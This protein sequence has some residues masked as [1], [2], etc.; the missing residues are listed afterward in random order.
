[1]QQGRPKST[2]S[3]MADLHWKPGAVFSALIASLV[4]QM[5]RTD[6][7]RW[8]PAVWI[9]A[10]IFAML[11]ILFFLWVARWANRNGHS[12][13]KS[14]VIHLAQGGA[15]LT[16]LLVIF[17]QLAHRSIGLGDA[18][19]VVVLLVVQ[20]ISWYL[21][22]FASVRGFERVSL[23]LC[24]A[25]VF[26]VCCMTNRMDVLVAGSIFAISS[27][28]WLVGLYWSRLESKAID[29]NPKVIAIHASATGI[30]SAAILLCLV[31]ASLVP[32]SRGQFALSGFMPFSGGEEGYQDEF[33]ASGVG[34]G[35]MLAAGNNAT[36]TGA[37]DSNQFIEDNKPS[38]YDVMTDQYEG[39]VFKKQRNRGVA[40][41]VKA[42]HIHDVKQSEQSGKSFRT[43]RNSDRELDVELEDRISTALLQIEGSVP[44]RFAIDCFHHFDGW[45]WSKVDT[46]QE[47]P[48][49][50]A[51]KVRKLTGKPFYVLQRSRQSYFT[52]G[53]THRV[54]VMRLENPNLPS[55]S[56]LKKWHIPRV[57]K[58]NMF[59]WNKSGVIEYD[60]ELIPPQ[61]A[62]DIVG[63][64]PNYHLMRDDAQLAE[65]SL[66]IDTLDESGD[67]TSPFLRLPDTDSKERIGCLAQD[68]TSQAKV[69]WNQ[70]E[71]IVHRFRNE[72]ELKPDWEVSETVDDTVSHF[73][74]QR[75]GPSYMFATSCAMVLRSAGYRTRL[76]SG[77]LIRHEDYDRRSKQSIVTAR[78]FHMW[79]EVCLDGKYWIPL[80][81]TPGYPIPYSTETFWQWAKA[82]FYAYIVAP[83]RSH[84]FTS[85]L[86]TL[87]IA[88]SYVYR[89]ILI[90]NLLLLWWHVVRITWPEGLLATTRQL[91]DV[92]F[93]FAGDARPESKTIQSWYTRV[94]PGLSSGF[95]ELWNI[96]NFCSHPRNFSREDIVS[97][98]QEQISAITLKRIQQLKANQTLPENS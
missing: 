65:N 59:S 39:P 6:Q 58:L 52:Q 5:F 74:D 37:V 22:V 20:T 11:P 23:L 87:A 8:I 15:A 10:V 30:A 61:T 70:V 4:M 85:T 16:A 3:R 31:I 24:G 45:D 84:P 12:N 77:F 9:E 38:M 21:A 80:E 90:T 32:I 46:T 89:A 83:I 71:E 94:E 53:R 88:L 51:I 43:M 79:P 27:L 54:K 28:W 92:R 81:P 96:K 98:C 19:E 40:L 36:T 73:L 82:T 76:A 93:W 29:G 62:I 26:F 25:I 56:F 60:G 63:Y 68:Y 48:L 14:S 72:F 75:G 50:P 69:G 2:E 95:F 91:I 66:Q 55:S 44:A 33:A 97:K 78:N 13:N 86:V 34:D 67:P 35:N 41:D 7:H 57:D 17:A 1:M 18:N 49:P 64:V 47:K 42:K